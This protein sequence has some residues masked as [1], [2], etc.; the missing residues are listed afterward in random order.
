MKPYIVS[1]NEFHSVRNLPAMQETWVLFL[2]WEDTLEKKMAICFSIFAWKIPR[3]EE[4]GGLQTM[5]SQRMR[6]DLATKPPP[7]SE[8]FEVQFVKSN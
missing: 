6:H 4:R 7:Q 8:F 1:M 3:T 5:G 2:G